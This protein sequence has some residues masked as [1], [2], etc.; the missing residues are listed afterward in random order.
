MQRFNTRLRQLSHGKPYEGRELK[1]L[2]KLL[3]EEM[4]EVIDAL[5]SVT[6]DKQREA[7]RL[8]VDLS[9]SDWPSTQ[10]GK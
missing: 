6:S 3:N 10:L 7:E 8:H 2:R 5:Y 4:D 1:R 9:H